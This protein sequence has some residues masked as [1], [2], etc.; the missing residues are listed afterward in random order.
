MK[1]KDEI[2]ELFSGKL[3]SYEAKVSPEL[4]G[5]VASQIGT[6]AAATTATGMSL[7]TK[8]IIGLGAA[9]VVTA[10]SI[11]VFSGKEEVEKEP[12]A[13]IEQA[14][15]T[16]EK[17]VKTVPQKE[18]EVEN[19]DSFV[20]TP[21][22]LAAPL[23]VIPSPTLPDPVDVYVPSPGEITLPGTTTPLEPTSVVSV[24]PEVKK[25]TL[26]EKNALA[27]D[28]I[29]VAEEELIT[30]ESKDIEVSFPN[31]FTPNNDGI[32][33][34]LF[35]KNAEELNESTFS[36]VVIDERNNEVYASADPNFRWNGYSERRGEMLSAGNYI[37]IITCKDKDGRQM[38]PVMRRFT[39][40]K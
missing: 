16:K 6:G 33:D 9:S 29:V 34:Y 25:D 26:I 10:T 39:I 32:N 38:K 7:T 13:Q 17:E 35:I 20:Y 5:K 31:I 22:P 37:A 23:P 8:L 28:P 36:I 12:F 24:E 11:A 3:G 18:K 1:G 19:E 40:A 4:W 15:D 21:T 30:E 2:K 27:S 14:V